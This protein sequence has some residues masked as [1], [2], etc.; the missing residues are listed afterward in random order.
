MKFRCIWCKTEFEFD[1][2]DR[3][4]GL[5]EIARFHFHAKS[6]HGYDEEIMKIFYDTWRERCQK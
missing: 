3:K 5:E 6:T 4:R 2:D 1:A